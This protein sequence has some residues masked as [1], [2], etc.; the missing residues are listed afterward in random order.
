MSY[1]R[2]FIT[3]I[4]WIQRHRLNTQM[5]NIHHRMV[6]TILFTLTSRMHA[7]IEGRNRFY[8]AECRKH[9]GIARYAAASTLVDQRGVL[10]SV[11]DATE[12]VLDWNHIAGGELEVVALPGVHQRRRV[13]QELAL[14][15]NRI[16]LL[17]DLV[18]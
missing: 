17:G 7:I 11:E 12:A 16:E 5:A 4:L 15:H 18:A 3:T 13:R 6:A 9:M 2:W 1:L 8:T 10:D 14:H